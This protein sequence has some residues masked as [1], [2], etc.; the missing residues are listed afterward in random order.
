MRESEAMIYLS[1][2]HPSALQHPVDGAQSAAREAHD[3]V[4]E[5]HGEGGEDLG[6]LQQWLLK[7]FH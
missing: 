5:D 6:L 2:V 3:V 4:G 1:P 7:I